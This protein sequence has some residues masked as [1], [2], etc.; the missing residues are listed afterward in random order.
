LLTVGLLLT[1]AFGNLSA[2]NSP[3][4]DQSALIE[5]M[6]QRID[7]L[8]R[9][10]N[11]LESEKR[12]LAATP[13]PVPVPASAVVAESKPA[14]PVTAAAP[15]SMPGMPMDMPP[16]NMTSYPTLHIAG[17]SDINFSA[18]DKHGDHPGFSEGQFVLH[19]S[20][21]LSQRVTYF[22]EL[23][24][25]ARADAGLGS[26][27]APGFNVEVERSIIRFEQNDHL[28]VSFG[29]Y[30]TPINYWN[31][32]FH[33]GS[34]LQTTISRP[35]MVQFGGSL[36]PVHFVG[37]L[38]E[39]SFA[40]DGLNLHYSSGV[41]NGRSS[42]I[43]RGGDFGDNNNFK[44]WLVNAYATPDKLYGLQIGA[45]LYRDKIDPNIGLP[46]REWIES[47]H[48]VWNKENPEFIAEFSNIS[49]T[50]VGTG[51]V[52]NTQA[53]YA[54]LAYRLSGNLRAWKPYY[55]YEYIHIP[56][57]DTIFAS[58]PE[59]SG[60]TV[61]VRYDISSFAALKFEY[62][63]QVRLGVPRINGLFSQVSFTF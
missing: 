12:A 46:A 32:Q 23:S 18:D 10:V 48:I 34:W 50:A 8:E 54:Q 43:S 38:A 61:G 5:K 25:T 30:H 6:L 55:R 49:H 9:R 40:A 41:G 29:R 14:A 16:A 24:F 17:F 47:A 51:H 35:E 20:S 27:P 36:L 31:T 37:A 1:F 63:N 39:G 33:H 26:P 57:G 42:V 58:V 45:S 4:H 44:A 2:Q 60:S 56:R 28:K 52:S 22:G 19:L 13:A 3:P 21:A 15:M 11:E 53:W 7:Q 59:L 62:R